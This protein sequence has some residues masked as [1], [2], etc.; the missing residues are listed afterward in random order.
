MPANH[1]CA[2]FGP[3]PTDLDIDELVER[4]ENFQFVPRIGYDAIENHGLEKF[5]KLVLMHVIMNGKPLVI[6]GFENKLEPWLF[7]PR[8]LKDNHG[9]KSTRHPSILCNISTS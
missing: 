1:P 2:A 5:E 3:I 9:N 4:T 6:D 7:T 8:W